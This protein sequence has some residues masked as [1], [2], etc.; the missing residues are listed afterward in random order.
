MFY[1]WVVVILAI[2][3]SLTLIL[4]TRCIAKKILEEDKNNLFILRLAIGIGT[5]GG[6]CFK[7]AN[8]TDADFSHGIL[9]S[10]NFRFANATR[11]FWRQSKYLKFARVE[12]TILVDI[13]VRELLITGD[14]KGKQYIGAS[15]RGANLISCLLYTSPSPRDIR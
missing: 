10:T 1:L 4:I 2:S 7:S 11:T 5:I 6:T 9:K 8:L 15:L 14:G 12:N 3:L 13:K